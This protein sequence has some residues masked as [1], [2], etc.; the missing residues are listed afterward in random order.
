M[1]HK[2][3]NGKTQVRVFEFDFQNQIMLDFYNSNDV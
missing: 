1:E 2:E 3:K